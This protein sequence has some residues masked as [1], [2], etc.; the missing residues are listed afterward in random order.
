MDTKELNVRAES[1]LDMFVRM[2]GR[3]V[4]LAHAVIKNATEDMK[5][6]EDLMDEANEAI[7]QYGKINID[8]HGEDPFTEITVSGDE[9]YDF[10]ISEI[11]IIGEAI[12][13]AITELTILKQFNNLDNLNKKEIEN[14]FKNAK[15]N[16]QNESIRM[17]AKELYEQDPDA[18][19]LW[20]SNKIR[21]VMQA[22]EESKTKTERIQEIGEEIMEDIKNAIKD[23]TVEAEEVYSN[24]KA[25]FNKAKASVKEDGLSD[26]AMKYI[27]VGLVAIAAIGIYFAVKNNNNDDI[28]IISD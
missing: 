7:A 22:E 24:S 3:I 6:Y 25:E 4:Y 27:K 23:A 20:L 15:P 14:L 12:F 11:G 1:A 17:K 19:I 21:G 10:Y 18:A 13:K 9:L 2:H 26:N 5:F 16:V 28:V 8:I